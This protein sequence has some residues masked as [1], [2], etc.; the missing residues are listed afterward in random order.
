[1]GSVAMGWAAME[2]IVVAQVASG[3][4]HGHAKSGIVVKGRGV[5]GCGDNGGGG[6]GGIVENGQC[7]SRFQ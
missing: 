6:G 1:M 5:V 7:S 2:H 4:G 3:N